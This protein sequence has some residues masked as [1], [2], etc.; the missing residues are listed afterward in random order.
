VVKT[1]LCAWRSSS[2]LILTLFSAQH[3]CCVRHKF[4]SEDVYKIGSKSIYWWGVSVAWKGYRRAEHDVESFIIRDYYSFIFFLCVCPFLDVTAQDYN[5][6]LGIPFSRLQGN[7]SMD[8]NIWLMVRTELYRIQTEK[9][10][11]MLYSRG[12][13]NLLHSY[14]RNV[15]MAPNNWH[16]AFQ[17][18]N[19]SVGQN[20]QILKGEKTFPGYG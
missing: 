2:D 8:L 3:S 20:P 6:S 13:Y 4:V 1:V 15:Y 18:I 10:V 7:S 9:F 12:V 5:V 19:Q 16:F 14:W 17:S 11:D